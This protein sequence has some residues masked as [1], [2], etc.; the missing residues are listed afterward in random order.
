MAQLHRAREGGQPSVLG[1]YALDVWQLARSSKIV[2]DLSLCHL[3]PPDPALPP[4]SGHW[5]L[6]M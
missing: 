1:K 2:R 4:V 5:F 6:L 3:Q